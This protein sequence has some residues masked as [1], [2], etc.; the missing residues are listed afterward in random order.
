[1]KHPNGKVLHERH[2]DKVVRYPFTSYDAGQYKTC[3]INES[4]NPTEFSF[5]LKTGIDAKDYSDLIT[6]KHLE[7]AGL[8]AQMLEDTVRELHKKY[9]FWRMMF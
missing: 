7:P 3:I 1:M 4:R 9:V 6:K 2:G 5:S 8:E